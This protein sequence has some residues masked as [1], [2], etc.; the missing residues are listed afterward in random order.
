MSSF[1]HLLADHSPV[2]LLDACSARVQIGWLVDATT[3]RWAASDAEAGIGVFNCINDLGILPPAAG[4]FVYCDGPGSILG[5]RTVA[6]ALRTWNVLAPKPTFSYHG[7]ELL[8][9]SIGRSDLTF[10]ADARR[11]TWHSFKLGSG[12]QRV[13]TAEL[14]G[15]LATPEG[16]RHW[17]TLPSTAAQVP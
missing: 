17:S 15:E 10:I 9:H 5:I 13:P 16:F 4:S 6:M 1:R 3:M 12:L 11:D 8:A 7:L 2:L 14:A